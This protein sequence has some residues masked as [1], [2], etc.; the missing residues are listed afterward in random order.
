MKSQG[1]QEVA[2]LPEGGWL[3][4]GHKLSLGSAANTR[5]L[6]RPWA[7]GVVRASPSESLGGRV[8]PWAEKRMSL[9]EAEATGL[10]FPVPWGLEGAGKGGAQSAQCGLPKAGRSGFLLGGAPAWGCG[11]FVCVPSSRRGR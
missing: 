6:S 10:W 5:T 1:N 4:S 8:C 3:L 11:T 2:F 7:S 9:G